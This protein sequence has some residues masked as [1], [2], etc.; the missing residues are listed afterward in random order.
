MCVKNHRCLVP[1][2]TLQQEAFYR[3]PMAGAWMAYSW[4][5]ITLKISSSFMVHTNCTVHHLLEGKIL[6]I[7]Q[8]PHFKYHICQNICIHWKLLHIMK[9]IRIISNLA[10]SNCSI[11]L[12]FLEVISMLSLLWHFQLDCSII[13]Q[14][15]AD[16][17]RHFAFRKII[18]IIVACQHS[19][20][21]QEN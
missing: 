11:I 8:I 16:M 4:P 18:H 6:L 10:L 7:P 20:I 3:Y 1:S 21:L 9:L 14:C 2:Q 12:K 5:L 13:I 15:R 17:C 19:F